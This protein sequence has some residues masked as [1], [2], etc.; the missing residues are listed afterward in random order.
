MPS[1]LGKPESEAPT[2]TADGTATPTEPTAPAAAPAPASE[3]QPT[4]P[5]PAA[6]EQPK[7]AGVDD[8]QKRLNAALAPA[9]ETEEPK[10]G[11]PA[12]EPAADP[13]PAEPAP[14]E[15]AADP[16]SEAPETPPAAQTP[17]AE[18]PKPTK[19]DFRP[20][21]NSLDE[22]QQ[23]AIELTKTL[24]DRGEKI[25]LA[26]AERRVNAKYGITDETPSPAEQPA[27]RTLEQVDADIATQ[28]AALRQAKRDMKIDDEFAAEDAIDALKAERQR[29]EASAQQAQ[30]SAAEAFEAAVDASQ[31]LAARVYPCMADPNHVIHVEAERIWK[32]M[33]KTRNPLITS[34]NAPMDVYTMA[35]NK[36]GIPP[37]DPDA[38][39]APAAPTATPAAVTPQSSPSA[40]PKPQPVAQQAVRSPKPAAAP[41]P[42]SARTTPPGPAQ[43][44]IGRIRTVNDYERTVANLVPTS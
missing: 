4:T 33:E 23:E 35:A 27:Q 1:D 9:K 17:A 36:L 40:T 32:T 15:P 30:V 41:V 44:S 25:S 37:E 14:V 13:A 38:E 43:P 24:A 18:A 6:A 39:P 3:S 5:P 31:E 34:E 26:E 2:P 8:Y 16:A 11:K 28:K 12:E 42:G 29:I 10:P 7:V 22:R 20:R 19:R 21:L